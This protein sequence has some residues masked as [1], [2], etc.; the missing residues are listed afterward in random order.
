MSRRMSAINSSNILSGVK[1]KEPRRFLGGGAYG[2]VVEMTYFGTNVAGKK[3]YPIFFTAN[4][5][6]I[7]SE[8]D[9]FEKEC[10]RYYNNMLLILF[11]V[12][13]VQ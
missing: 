7:Q 12:H 9:R 3:M 4:E 8:V 13:C 5:E 2:E 10:S 1:E 11:T 6:E